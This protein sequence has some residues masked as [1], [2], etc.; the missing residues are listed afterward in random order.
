[1]FSSLC[2]HDV[3]RTMEAIFKSKKHQAHAW[4]HKLRKLLGFCAQVVTVLISYSIE[5]DLEPGVIVK[6][7]HIIYGL[8]GVFL[9]VLGL[10]LLSSNELSLHPQAAL[11]LGAGL[12]LTAVAVIEYFFR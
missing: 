11:E 4:A 5:E 9:I 10:I 7:R 6:R 8:T 12:A 2:L 1:M 3:G